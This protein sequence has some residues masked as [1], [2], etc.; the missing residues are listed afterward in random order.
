[1]GAIKRT[2]RG[3]TTEGRIGTAIFDRRKSGPAA[4]V[5]KLTSNKVPADSSNNL[6]ESWSDRLPPSDR[7]GG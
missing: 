1:M 5:R 6:I 3:P 7:S 4:Q 2:S